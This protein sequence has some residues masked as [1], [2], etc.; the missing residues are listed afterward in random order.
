MRVEGLKGKK[1]CSYNKKNLF[2]QRYKKFRYFF[3]QDT[4]KLLVEG[5]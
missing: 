2:Q 5:G 1:M 3:K 4:E